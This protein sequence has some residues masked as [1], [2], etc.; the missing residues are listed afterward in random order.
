MRIRSS[1][2]KRAA[3]AAV[4]V[5]GASTLGL[6]SA[7]AN[8]AEKAALSSGRISAVIN[9]EITGEPCAFSGVNPLRELYKGLGVHFSGPSALD[10]AA[11]LHECSGFGVDARSG[12]AFLALNNGATMLNGGVPRGPITI[13]FDDKQ[14]SVG[15][16]VSTGGPGTETFKLVGKRGGAVISTDTLTTSTNTF[17][18]LRVSSRNGLT[19]VIIRPVTLTDG[20][21]VVDDLSIASL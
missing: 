15:I 8:D 5:L 9:F 12:E 11:I 18:A 3:V 7:Q 6:A 19:S 2:T 14:R 21:W 10:G 16:W 13:R 17:E 20:Q 1:F 4:A